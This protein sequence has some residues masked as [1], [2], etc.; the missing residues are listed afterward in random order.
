[1]IVRL[2]FEPFGLPELGRWPPRFDFGVCSVIKSNCG[3]LLS[4]NVH[5][6][7][8]PFLY[9]GAVIQALIYRQTAPIPFPSNL[10]V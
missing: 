4:E 10:L 6:P 5:K 7:I 8:K 2:L 3:H 9:E 1:M